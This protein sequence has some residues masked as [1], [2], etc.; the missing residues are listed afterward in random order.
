MFWTAKTFSDESSLSWLVEKT[1]EPCQLRWSD[2][3]HRRHFD[4]SRPVFWWSYTGLCFI[5][6]YAVSLSRWRE[7]NSD[8]RVNR[9]AITASVTFLKPLMVLLGITQT[10][11]ALERER[12]RESSTPL[13]HCRD[14]NPSP[15]FRQRDISSESRRA[16]VEVFRKFTSSDIS[17]EFV[18]L[19]FSSSFELKDIVGAQKLLNQQKLTRIKTTKNLLGDYFSSGKCVIKLFGSVIMTFLR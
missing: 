16:N 14:S 9:C 19:A 12:E 17:D 10:Q 1:I 8:A 2:F 4:E 7:L 5:H 13:K 15:S 3:W 6:L 18:R 11:T